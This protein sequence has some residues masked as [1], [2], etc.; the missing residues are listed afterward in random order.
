MQKKTKELGSKSDLETKKLLKYLGMGVGF[1]GLAVVIW[2][3]FRH[4]TGKT[5]GGIPDPTVE[6]PEGKVPTHLAA[7]QEHKEKMKAQGKDF[8]DDSD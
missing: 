1:A 6:L 3:M 5:N 7:I 4:F 2:L 8:P